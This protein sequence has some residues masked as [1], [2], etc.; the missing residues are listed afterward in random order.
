MSPRF[1]AG[2]G[3]TMPSLQDVT[4]YI[5]HL[6]SLVLQNIA[7]DELKSLTT[8]YFPYLPVFTGTFAPELTLFRAR[9]NNTAKPYNN[10]RDIGI[11]PATVL[12]SFGRANKPFQPMFYASW[13]AEVAL[14][15]TCQ[16]FGKGSC[17]ITGFAT[18]GT[19]G[20]HQDTTLS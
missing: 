6:E 18:I 20:L 16:V 19:W 2:P 8:S 7:Y 14:L 3:V 17:A 11:P 13:G 15:E 4:K 12:T 1:Q 10:V 5:S 9:L